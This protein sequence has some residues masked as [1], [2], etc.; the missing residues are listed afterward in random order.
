MLE[1]TPTGANPTPAGLFRRTGTWAEEVQTGL[2]FLVGA[3][4]LLYGVLCAGSPP[5]SSGISEH[6]LSEALE[7]KIRPEVS[8][9]I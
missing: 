5:S 1:K 3:R 7:Q 9:P 8:H 4:R 2:G 6:A